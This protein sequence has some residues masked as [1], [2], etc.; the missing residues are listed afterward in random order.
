MIQI[1]EKDFLGI[2]RP[3][4]MPG[5]GEA[6]PFMFMGHKTLHGRPKPVRRFI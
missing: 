5:F 2:F 4:G 6:F 3:R 1:E